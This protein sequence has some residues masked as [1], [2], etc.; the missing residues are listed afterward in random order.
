MW[1]EKI[2]YEH[3]LTPLLAH[4]LEIQKKLKENAYQIKR[5][6][7][8]AQFKLLEIFEIEKLFFTNQ[9]NMCCLY[10]NNIFATV[11]AVYLYYISA[12]EHVPINWN[13]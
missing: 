3:S 10:F 13:E 4:A 1:Y 12:T 7:A 6:F 9:N 5:T 2:L 8:F 11:R